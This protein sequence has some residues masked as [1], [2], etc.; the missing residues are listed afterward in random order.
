V[1]TRPWLAWLLP[2]TLLAGCGEATDPPA[3]GTSAPTGE[4]L[5][6]GLP[7]PFDGGD[8]LR[9]TLGDER[10]DYSVGCNGFGGEL[11]WDGDRLVVRALSATE[12]GCPGDGNAEEQWLVEFL[13]SRP[14]ATTRGG[15][16]VLSDGGD[17]ITLEPDDGSG[18][19]SGRDRPLEGTRWRLQGIEETAGY[20]VSFRSLAGSAGVG[21]RLEDGEIRFG[22]G[23]NTGSGDV[24]V[25]G[26]TLVLG[27][28]VVTTRG[29]LDAREEVE[30]EV[31][32]VLGSRRVD[33]S[34]DGDRLRLTVGGTTLLYEPRTHPSPPG[35]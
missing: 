15:D 13:Q 18:H 30:Q 27:R 24:S 10:L 35:G 33:W 6:T 26:D 31:L 2:V 16:V 14:T 1:T 8:T 23:C 20:S 21:L 9:L 34:V 17:E 11:A 4:Y 3:S 19:G 22:T 7:G 5:A 25:T 29:C 12:M 32:V 28:V